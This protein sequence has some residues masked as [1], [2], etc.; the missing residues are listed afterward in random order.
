[1]IIVETGFF[2]TYNKYGQPTGL[3]EFGVSH[4]YDSVT[5]KNVILEQ[6]KWPTAL[7]AVWNKNIGEWVIYETENN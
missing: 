7:G 4:G 3:K 2:E 5:G 1:M 6:V